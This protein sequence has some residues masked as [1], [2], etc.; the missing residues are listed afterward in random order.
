LILFVMGF[1]G[2]TF[3]QQQDVCQEYI[4]LAEQRLA[5]PY[6]NYFGAAGEYGHAAECYDALGQT[7][8]ATTYFQKAADHY[9]TAAKTLVE[10]GDYYQKAKS[11]EFAG[12][13]LY[14]IGQ[15]DAALQDY[16]IAEQLYRT[17][18]FPDDAVSL[19]GLISQR[20]GINP[21]TQS[22]VNIPVLIVVIAAIG[23]LGFWFFK[24]KPEGYKPSDSAQ[25]SEPDISS[26]ARD[27]PQ[28]TDNGVSR[29]DFL[30]SKVEPKPQDNAARDDAKAKM[31]RKIRE[32]YG[33]EDKQE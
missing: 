11:Y 6:P 23:G 19:T 26:F 13:S 8:I 14:R 2:I 15:R 10:G 22:N 3:A 31:A 1:V 33:L 20:F 16:N 24:K 29:K 12:N 25:P 27:I 30:E 28:R 4:T 17:H 7:D 18:N 5:P 32:R 9:I 21:Q